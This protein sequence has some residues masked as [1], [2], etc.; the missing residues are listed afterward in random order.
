LRALLLLLA[1]SSPAAAQVP[2]PVVAPEMAQGFDK[3][4]GIY[5][6]IDT[7]RATIAR[8]RD[9]IPGPRREAIGAA[10]GNPGGLS[11]P[12]LYALA[13]ALAQDDA[14]IEEAV[15]WYHIGRIRAVFDGLRCK[16]PTARGAVNILGRTLN[17]DIARYQRQRRPRTVEIAEIAVRWDAQNPYLYDHRWVNLYGKVA[18]TSPGTDPGELSVPESEWPAILKHVHEAHLKSVREFAEQGGKGL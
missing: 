18:R 9:L 13:N 2:P 7:Q 5:A 17:P 11:P 6:Q 12:A 3:P 15:F 8:L 16:D 4:Q 14:R 10:L 1:L